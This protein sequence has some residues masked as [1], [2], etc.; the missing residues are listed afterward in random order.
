MFEPQFFYLASALFIGNVVEAVTGFGGPIIA[1]TLAA[2][3]FPIDYLVPIIVPVILC[4]N[5]YIVL[6]HRN[7]I[8]SRILIGGWRGLFS[9]QSREPG[10]NVYDGILPWAFS[11]MLLGV[12]IF[13]VADNMLLK[14]LYGGF[15]LCFSVSGFI[16]MLRPAAR[17]TKPLRPAT[18]LILLIAGGVM[19]G[20]YAA[21]GPLLVYYTNRV[22]TDKGSFRATLSVVWLILNFSVFTSHLCTGKHTPETLLTVVALLP[23]LAV[24]ILIGEKLHGRIPERGFR[25]LVYSILSLSGISLM[26]SSL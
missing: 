2:N 21:G 15:I 8:N 7:H 13:S 26:Y 11:G 19:Q 17:S 9:R 5:I 12:A 1:V 23:V 4:M 14:L 10:W 20:I 22:L 3:F 24:G 25:M 18:G 6:R 16:S